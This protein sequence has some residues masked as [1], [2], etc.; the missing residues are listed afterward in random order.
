[1]TFMLLS[2]VAGALVCGGCFGA[3]VTL[4]ILYIKQKDGWPR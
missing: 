4:F 1:M 3:I 2:Q